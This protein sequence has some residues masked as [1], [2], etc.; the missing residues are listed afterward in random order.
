MFGYILINPKSLSQAEKARYR[1]AYCGL[2][3]RLKR[4]GAEARATLS[5][6][7]KF[8]ALLLNSIYELDE[9]HGVERCALRPVPVHKYFISEATDYA[10]DVNILL[11]YYKALDDWNDEHDKTA[12]AR[13]EKLKAYLPVIGQKRP[14]LTGHIAGCIER[15]TEMERHNMLNPDYP[16][17]CFGE[18]MGEILDWRGEAAER[19]SDGQTGENGD[20]AAAETQPEE[21]PGAALRRMGEALGRFVYLLDACNDLRD[22]IRKER[23]NPLIA[24]MDMDFEPLLTMLIGECTR[25][26]EK[27]GAVRDIHLLRNVLYS[28]VWM[29]YHG[30]R[31][32]KAATYD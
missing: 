30:K 25:E 6:D 1:E 10:A 11:S 17:N 21:R 18:M 31:A 28:G 4:Y 5:Y 20:Q 26:F 13:S 9:E 22:D 23:Y 8:V 3:R 15:L 16:A 32:R 24:Q 2:C 29:R 14:E 12:F 27:I 19:R 7:M